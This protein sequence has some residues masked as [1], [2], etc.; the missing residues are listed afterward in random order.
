VVNSTGGEASMTDGTYVETKE[1]MG[2]FWVVQAP[3]MD[4]ALQLGGWTAP[5]VSD[6][7]KSGRCR[8]D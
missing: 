7:W 5:R 8:D 6:R 2:G 3:G 4:A 1:Q